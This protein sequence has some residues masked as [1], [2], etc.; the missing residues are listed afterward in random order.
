MKLKK[1]ACAIDTDI[2]IISEY[3]VISATVLYPRQKAG[4]RAY[5]VKTSQRKQKRERKSRR[6]ARE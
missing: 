3:T 1:E 6:K 4:D 2:G 5:R